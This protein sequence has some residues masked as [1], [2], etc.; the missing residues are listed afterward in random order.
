[1]RRTFLKLMGASL[2]MAGLGACTRQPREEI[3]PY[4]VQP[5]EIVPGRPLFYATAMPLGGF[6]TGVLVEAHLGRPTKIEGNPDHPASLGATGPFQQASLLGL[7]DPD[8]AQ[9]IQHLGEIRP[10]SDLLESLRLSMEALAADRGEGLRILT[11]TVTS[12]TLAAQIQELRAALPEMRWHQYEPAG[13]DTR[14][15][16][17]R[18]AFGEPVETYYRLEDADVILSLEGDFLASGPAH[19][20]Y[21]REFS[22]R[23]RVDQGA[24]NR[25]YV[26]ESSPTVTGAKADHRLAL[27]SADVEALAEAIA[28]AV[29]AELN[30]SGEPAD[31]GAWVRAVARD[32]QAHRGRSAVIP[33]DGQ[34]ARVHA[35]AHAMN[36]ALG[37]VGRTVV[38]IDPVEAEPV[39]QSASLAEL[40]RD[41]NDGRVRLLVVLG[42]N[43]VYDA[44]ADL[45]FGAALDKVGLRIRLGDHEDETSELCHWN[46]PRAHYLE[47]WSDVRAY[48]G[49]VSLIQPLLEPLWEAKTD[50]EMLA[51]M[52]GRPTERPRD[53]VRQH[54]ESRMGPDFDRSWNRALHDGLVPGTAH[55]PREVGMRRAWDPGASG[56]RREDMEIVFRPDP[57]VHDGAFANN[58]WLQELPKPITRLTWDNAA[59]LAPATATRLGLSSEDVVELRLGERSVKAP[60][61]V[62]PGQAEGSVTV[63]LGYGRSRCGRVAEGAGFDAYVLRT[64]DAPA[65]RGGLTVVPVGDRYPLACTQTHHSMEGRHLVRSATL[66]HFR[67]HPDFAQHMVHDPGPEMTLYPEHPYEGH[68]WGMTI[69]LNSCIGCGACVVACQSENNIPVVGKEQVGV[70]REMHWL[71]VDRYYSGEMDD[72]RFHHQPVPCMHCEDAPCELVCPVGATVHSSEGLNDMVYNR[73]VGTRYCSNNCPYKVRRFNFFNFNLDTPP[74]LEMVK[75]PDVTVRSRGVMEKC[76]YCVQRIN[77]ARIVAH[78]EDRSIRDGEIVTAC[79]AACPAKAITFGDINDPASRV[80]ARKGEPRNYALLGEVNTRPRTTYLAAVRNPNPELEPA[81]EGE[82]G[83]GGHDEAEG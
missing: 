56:A 57:T 12:P 2:A 33:G 44:P 73:C 40:V 17:A 68:A 42:G 69:D 26:A 14:R 83:T 30:G 6:G 81:A 78:K 1:G 74:T 20:R 61:W 52:L 77:Q 10:W 80:S 9:T 71:R 8:R 36:E 79:E 3:V 82:Q 72:P 11:G 48:D 18:L 39:D 55:P 53:S 16:G 51:A 31:H 47:S 59:M 32:L 5:E 29:G 64:S 60:V 54:W 43:P 28:V 75:N 4:V 50:H 25:L 76:T 19:L 41:M 21:A 37:N 45:G 27:R 46:V 49:T 23:R 22:R 63:H 58:G 35:L 70:G 15:A 38:H 66:E 7:Y 67:E 65:F 62:Q 24:M 34:P 13:R